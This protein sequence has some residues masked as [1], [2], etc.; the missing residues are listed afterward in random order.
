METQVPKVQT[1]D[2]VSTGESESNLNFKTSRP[3]DSIQQLLD[4]GFTVSDCAN[5]G[6]GI[7]EL[8]AVPTVTQ[9]DIIETGCF[10]ED[11]LIEYLNPRTL[12][13]DNAALE[14]K[15]DLT[16]EKIEKIRNSKTVYI[17]EMRVGELV[18]LKNIST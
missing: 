9:E 11:E 13:V 2:E 14:E 3:S 5:A 17:P 4:K 6:H 1:I 12:H 18:E 10:A 16:Q 15:R 8:S 7:S